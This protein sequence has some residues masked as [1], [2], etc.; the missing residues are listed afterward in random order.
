MKTVF[1]V[2]VWIFNHTVNAENYRARKES[3]RIAAQRK[4]DRA[5]KREAERLLLEDARIRVVEWLHEEHDYYENV[6]KTLSNKRERADANFRAS[7]CYEWACYA[8]TMPRKTF[9]QFFTE[10]KTAWEAGQLE[11]AY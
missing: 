2:L 8:E 11:R 4:A 7:K 10:L 5:A 3:E 1:S 6:A 9:L